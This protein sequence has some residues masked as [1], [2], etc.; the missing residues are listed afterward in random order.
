MLK[1]KSNCSV[2]FLFHKKCK[3]NKLTGFSSPV[4]FPENLQITVSVPQSLELNSLNKRKR[5]IFDLEYAIVPEEYSLFNFL[6]LWHT[7]AGQMWNHAMIRPSSGEMMEA[8]G[9]RQSPA[10]VQDKSTNTDD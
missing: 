3:G 7:L 4:N 10:S 1:N 5:L 8:C 6:I 9:H 2:L